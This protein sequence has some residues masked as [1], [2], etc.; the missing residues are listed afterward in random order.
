[1]TDARHLTEEERQGAADGSLDAGRLGG[2]ER[3]IESCVEC[4]RDVASLRSLMARIPT[5]VA[6][7]E[8]GDLWPSIRSKI[9]ASKV[10][11]LE[12]P[13]DDVPRR[14]DRRG[15]PW[16]IGALVA[17]A[18]IVIVSLPPV[19]GA[20]DVTAPRV[21]IGSESDFIN[22][23]D[24]TNSY[25]AEATALLNQ[26]ELQRAM[27]PPAARVSVDHDLRVIDDA[28]AEVKAAI[29]RDPNN[30]ALRRLLASSYRQKVELLKRA[31]GAS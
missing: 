30:P 25:E 17:A 8:L 2:V 20:R 13:A 28:I 16:F 3:H 12:A 18:A 5:P 23:A 29:E 19:R 1:M 31:S 9:E 14:R 15:V 10:V 22:I 7:S 21:S 4:A 26:L 27:M 11:S 24:S 6:A